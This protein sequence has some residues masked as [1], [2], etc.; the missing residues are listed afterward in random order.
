[1]KVTLV[2][3]QIGEDGLWPCER[4]LGVDEPALLPERGEECR[5]RLCVGEM[6]LCSE[7]Y[8]L[9]GGMSSGDLLQ[10]EPPEQLREDTH[11]QEEVG[12]A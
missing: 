3:R 5:K 12:L 2:A 9:A 10:H 4:A 8:E 1:L 7:E 6:R 11:G